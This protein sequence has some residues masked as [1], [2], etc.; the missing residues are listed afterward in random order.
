MPQ[1]TALYDEFTVNETL[2]FFGN[3]LQMDSDLLCER[4]EMLNKLLELPPDDQRVQ[5]CSGGQKR[6]ISLAV[7]MIHDPRLLNLDEPTVGLD[8]ILREK[9]W[10]YI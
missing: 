4:S 5:D 8:P 1:E 6:R 2:N 7:A 9:I 10:N 3:I